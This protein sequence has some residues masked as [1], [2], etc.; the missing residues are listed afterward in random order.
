MNLA[1]LMLSP[2]IQSVEHMVEKVTNVLG[3]HQFGV[4]LTLRNNITML[5]NH[6]IPITSIQ[7]TSLSTTLL[8]QNVTNHFEF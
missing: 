5:S 7:F 2:T 6:E 4:A 3:G 1:W 8:L